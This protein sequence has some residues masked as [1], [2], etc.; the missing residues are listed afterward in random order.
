MRQELRDLGARLITGTPASPGGVLVLVVQHGYGARHLGL[1]QTEMI[2]AWVP[3]LLFALLDAVTFGV[4]STARI[5]TGAA[6]II[7]VVFGA[8]ALGELVMFQQLGV[9]IAVALLLDAT[10]VRVV[11]V[12][13]AMCLLGRWNWFPSR[14]AARAPARP[15]P[16]LPQERHRVDA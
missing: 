7:V 8:L 2:E 12:P 15:G 1:Q 4:A 14:L 11:L 6:L 9:G 5:I 10:V 3:M 13:A 16:W